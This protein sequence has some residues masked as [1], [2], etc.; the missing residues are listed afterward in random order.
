MR[1]GCA[2]LVSLAVCSP[3]GIAQSELPDAD[4]TW[5]VGAKAM[6][7]RNSQAPLQITLH[8][9]R[10]IAVPPQD[11]HE[12]G[13]A[14]IRSAMMTQANPSVRPALLFVLQTR[15]TAPAGRSDVDV[16]LA[17][18]TIVRV[19]AVDVHDARLTFLRTTLA[20]ERSRLAEAARP[21]GAPPVWGAPAS[22][23][24]VLIQFDTKG[25]EFG[26]WVKRFAA[27][28]RRN[29]I[30]EL[31]SSTEA[32]VVRGQ[33]VAT[34]TVHRD[35]T[36]TGV[37][38]KEPSAVAAFNESVLRGLMKTS[39]TAPLPGDYPEESVV[40]TITFNINQPPRPQSAR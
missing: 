35:G 39:P 5:V 29:W 17:S 36:L 20:Q 27:E 9:G 4:H 12:Y 8:S 23:R 11:V 16:T 14:I 1:S 2:L 24:D 13:T 22:D 38:I 30:E 40:F 3:A 25:V 31:T 6:Q 37:S 32:N 7:Q 19:R 10:R 15:G 34:F 18:G 33:V 21:R 26:R 28:L